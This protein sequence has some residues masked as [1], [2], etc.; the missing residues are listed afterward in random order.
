MVTSH[1]DHFLSL[2]G[3]DIEDNCLI[4]VVWTTKYVFLKRSHERCPQTVEETT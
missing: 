2:C 1:L 3:H 4:S